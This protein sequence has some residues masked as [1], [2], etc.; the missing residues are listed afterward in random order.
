MLM[1][2]GNIKNNAINGD[3]VITRSMSKKMVIEYD[4][5]SVNEKILIILINECLMQIANKKDS[6][7]YEV[8]ENEEDDDEWED[9]NTN[10]D[11]TQLN[12]L[13]KYSVQDE[14][15]DDDEAA[16][17][18]D[19]V[20]DGIN[21]PNKSSLQVIITF[22]KTITNTNEFK[23]NFNELPKDQQN[24]LINVLL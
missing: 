23:S 13:L 19:D 18:V 14:D 9:I 3:G 22:L 11:Y 20:I 24:D 17:E 10:M 7:E 4:Q 16:A 6:Y 2:K 15:E 8:D 1:V 12:D 5:I 21:I